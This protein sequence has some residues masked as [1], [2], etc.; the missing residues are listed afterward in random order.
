MYKHRPT[1]EYRLLLF[2]VD[3]IDDREDRTGCF[4]L[5]LGS[6][7]PPRYIGAIED[8]GSRNLNSS[9]L[10]R[11]SLHWYPLQDHTGSKVVIVFDTMSESFRHMRAPHAPARSYIFEMDATLAIHSC[12]KKTGN[13]NIWVLQNYEGEDWEQLYKIKLPG[14]PQ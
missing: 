6:D 1:G 9:V 4:I 12:D 8:V 7:Q 11:G 2:L 14:E 5:T 13:V 10:L 3:E